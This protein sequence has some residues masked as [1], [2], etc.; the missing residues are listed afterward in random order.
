[1]SSQARSIHSVDD[2]HFV[3]ARRAKAMAEAA[4]KESCNKLAAHF[5]MILEREL[6]A[7]AARHA[8]LHARIIGLETELDA[9]HASTLRMRCLRLVQRLRRQL[10]SRAARRRSADDMADIATPPTT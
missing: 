7:V 4:A 6:G 8:E 2:A 10:E 5:T 1:M 3:S 9:L